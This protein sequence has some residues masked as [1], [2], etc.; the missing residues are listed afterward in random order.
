[1]AR[2][3]AATVEEYLNELT[4]DRRAVVSAVREVVRRNLPEGSRE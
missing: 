4:E 2:S 3:N 1:M